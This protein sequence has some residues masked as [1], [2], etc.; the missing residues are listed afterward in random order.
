MVPSWVLACFLA[1]SLISPLCATPLAYADEAVTVIDLFHATDEM[2]GAQVVFQGEAIGDIISAGDGY[3]W[4]T[5]KASS[6]VAGR[7]LWG[8]RE[9]QDD[10]NASVSVYMTAA[11][12]DLLTHLGRYHVTGTTLEVKGVYHLACEAHQGQSG[13]HAVSVKAISPGAVIDE[14]PDFRLLALGIALILVGFMFFLLFRFLRERE[15]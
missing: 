8:A 3:V 13:V 9:R 2:D 12:S 5:L 4:V 15:R 1:S 14:D 11:D 10:T 7:S 6:D